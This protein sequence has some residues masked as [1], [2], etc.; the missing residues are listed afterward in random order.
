VVKKL[1]TKAE[2]VLA[3]LNDYCEKHKQKPRLCGATKE[4]RD[5]AGNVLKLGGGLLF[6][7]ALAKG[8]K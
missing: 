6:V 8:I 1:H 3:I 5:L 7:I 2:A 4:A